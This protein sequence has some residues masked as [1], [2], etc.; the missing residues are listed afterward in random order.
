MPRRPLAVAAA[1]AASLAASLV[2]PARGASPV[3]RVTPAA[4]AGEWVA[5]DFHV[6][7]IFGHDTCITPA[8]RWDEEVPD[9][10]ARTSCEDPYV[11]GFRP[12]D[13]LADAEAR[14]LDFVALTDHNN[15][16][17]QTDPD[18]ARYPGPV[19]RIPAYEN[20]QPGHV[21]MLGAR[22]C[23]GN[24]GVVP[25]V[26]V[27]CHREV[28]DQ[29]A[30]GERRLADSLRADG[31]AFQVNHP[32]DGEWA[33]RYGHAVVP[34]TVEV[35]NIGGWWFQR[36]FP[37]ANDNDASLA[38]YDGFLRAG[39]EVAA[40]GGSDSHW[41]LTS[42]FQGIGE[43]TTWVWVTERS[44]QG[45]L[46]GL[47]AH[48]TTISTEPPA[49][50]G[51]RVFLEADAD[52]DGTYEAMV[53]DR[54]PPG[55]RFRVRTENALPG[56]V[57]RVVTEAGHT[58]TTLTGATH[59]FD[60]PARTF[61]RVEVRVP[62]ALSQRTAT[63]DPLARSLEER[64]GEEF[65]YCRN[66]LVVQ[67]LTSP[68]YVREPAAERAATT[69]TWTGDTAA[70]GGSAELAARLAT[71]TGTPVAGREVTFETANG[72]Y[73]AA[74][75]ADGVARV[76]GAFPDHGRRQPVAA[77]FAGDAAYLPSRVTA[78]L[79]WGAG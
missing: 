53:G 68:V 54:V 73:V 38:F 35:W 3:P 33:G 42:Q 75:G 47:R 18:L 31:G 32:S 15:V 41:Q 30:A 13:R 62:D 79:V 28:R 72:T 24:D 78:T 59:E 1:L 23:Y 43:P 65:T 26:L 2:A 57:L 34:D 40:T 69:L 4:P 12:A 27:Q 76:T 17:G 6:H 61:V 64:F 29:S 49:R 74:T 25:N 77:S 66:R 37:S 58:E 60:S 51:P 20:S 36:P 19:L 50:R 10:A 21:Q 70:R 67:A 56:S 11:V 9:H 46:D 44:V 8:E 16:V 55:A 5:G 39:H 48:R 71:A 7:T 63:C 22:G 52:R 14:G 45:V